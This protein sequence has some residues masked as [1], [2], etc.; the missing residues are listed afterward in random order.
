MPAHK[1]VTVISTSNCAHSDGFLKNV[2]DELKP[3]IC[4]SNFRLRSCSNYNGL[5]R[6]FHLFFDTDPLCR[7]NPHI[8]FVFKAYGSQIYDLSFPSGLDSART[9]APFGFDIFGEV[10]EEIE[11]RLTITFPA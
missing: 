3:K 5:Q 10:D 7:S 2:D 1:T 8:G 4:C 6:L 9:F 11:L